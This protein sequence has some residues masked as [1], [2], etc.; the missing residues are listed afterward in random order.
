MKHKT[1]RQNFSLVELIAQP[2]KSYS[3]KINFYYIIVGTMHNTI[4]N[5]RQQQPTAPPSLFPTRTH[6]P[7]PPQHNISSFYIFCLLFFIMKPLLLLFLLLFLYIIIILITRG[8][9]FVLSV[10][11]CTRRPGPTGSYLL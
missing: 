4:S 7:R 11:K 10:E 5:E 2:T 8:A 6:T 3:Y 1:K 9:C